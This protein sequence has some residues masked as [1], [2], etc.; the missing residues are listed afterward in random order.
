MANS[1]LSNQNKSYKIPEHVIEEVRKNLLKNPN[2]YSTIRQKAENIV[3]NKFLTYEN[4]K[5]VKNFFDNINEVDLDLESMQ[6]ERHRQQNKIDFMIMGGDKMKNWIESELKQA[7]NPIHRSKKAKTN[8]GGLSN[9]FRK[10]HTKSFLKAPEMPKVKNMIKD[11]KP[12]TLMENDDLS[13]DLPI[14]LKFACVCIVF[15]EENKLLLVKRSENDNWM[16]GKYALIGG[17]VEENEIPEECIIREA[18]EETN[19]TLKKPKLVYSTIEGR[20][21]LY[22]FVSKVTNSDKIKLNDEHTGYVWLDS[23]EIEKYDTVP[24]LME[25]IR[26]VHSILLANNE[27]I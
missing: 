24:N 20:T 6:R 8:F 15:N 27:G 11:L 2:T 23:G 26:K 16:A 19:L 22:V 7:R 25:M 17:G 5:R 21:F 3:Q 1:K 12:K 13:I 14:K 18:K 9:Q 4:L 10:E